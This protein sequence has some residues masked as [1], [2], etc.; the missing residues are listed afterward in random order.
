MAD[1]SSEPIIRPAGPGDVAVIRRIAEN[2]YEHYVPR[3]GR[4]PAPMV[5]D[6]EVHVSAGEAFVLEDGG[7]VLG[8]IIAG[9]RPDCL[10][11]DNMA[12]DPAAQGRG[13][14]RR[15]MAWSET[16]A[17]QAGLPEVRLYT[18]VKMTENINFYTRLGF[19]ETHRVTENGF[20]RVYLK[21]ELA[22]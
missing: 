22:S 10:F 5:A 8:F 2:A 3:I 14:G 7:R 13:L 4:K 1:P 6:F 21:K 9:A 12:V 18:N 11:V 16:A 17:R 20:D 19:S 15:L